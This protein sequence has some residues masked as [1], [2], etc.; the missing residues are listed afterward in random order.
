MVEFKRQLT[1]TGKGKKNQATAKV[2]REIAG[3][4]NS[5][6]GGMLL[7]GVNDDSSIQGIEEDLPRTNPQKKNEDGFSL[8]LSQ[9]V[10]DLLGTSV[11]KFIEIKFVKLNQKRVCKILIRPSPNPVF[12]EGNFIL[13]IGTEAKELT[14]EEAWEAVR[15]KRA[16]IPE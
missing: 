8:Y 16:I 11:W 2:L 4:L 14:V 7:I 12:F 5:N 10:S 3:F 13:R 15:R 9:K 1:S 6:T